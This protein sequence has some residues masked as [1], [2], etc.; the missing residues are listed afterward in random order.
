M[1]VYVCVCMSQNEERLA[2]LKA[3]LRYQESVYEEAYAKHVSAQ[4]T[5]D[6]GVKELYMVC[7]YIPSWWWWW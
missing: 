1:C 4:E 7:A 2:S 5:F 6:S 3:E